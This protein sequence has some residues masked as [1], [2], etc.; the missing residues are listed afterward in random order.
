LLFCCRPRIITDRTSRRH[1]AFNFVQNQNMF[2]RKSTASKPANSEQE[3]NKDTPSP[4]GNPFNV[5]RRRSSTASENPP[6]ATLKPDVEPAPTQ[7]RRRSLIG[8]NSI[9]R[10]RSRSLIPSAAPSMDFNQVQP[11]ETENIEIAAQQTANESDVKQELKT[12]QGN[13]VRSQSALPVLRRHSTPVLSAA[14]S[15]AK[16]S[17]GNSKSN[18]SNSPSIDRLK[19]LSDGKSTADLG[20]TLLAENQTLQTRLSTLELQRETVMK[21]IEGLGI[22]QS[23]MDLLL[24][25]ADS[26]I[27]RTQDEQSHLQHLLSVIHQKS[28]QDAE[29]GLIYIPSH[30]F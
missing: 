5:L 24:N 10:R 23:Q 21:E 12:S 11:K 17:A 26:N 19:A 1:P 4:K 7:A 25:S 27:Q 15:R 18:L 8:E 14:S 13:L 6:P 29:L 30:L 2:R 3:G 16:L 22:R 28:K 9:F 20:Q